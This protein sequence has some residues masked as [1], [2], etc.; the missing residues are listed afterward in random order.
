MHTYQVGDKEE[1]ILLG[2][3][4]L[5]RS[6]TAIARSYPHAV[7]HGVCGVDGYLL[8]ADSTIRAAGVKKRAPSL[9]NSGIGGKRDTAG[10]VQGRDG[11]CRCTI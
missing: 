2:S 9:I 11:F 1:N 6:S 10:C 8:F 7:G 5:C 4:P 3:G